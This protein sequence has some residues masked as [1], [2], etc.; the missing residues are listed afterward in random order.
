MFINNTE[1]KMK[2]SYMDVFM[3]K[4]YV[5]LASFDEGLVRCF[6]LLCDGWNKG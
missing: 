6:V 3:E 1:S 4:A 2:V 5:G